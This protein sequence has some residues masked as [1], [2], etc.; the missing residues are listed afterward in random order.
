MATA[1]LL[2]LL[3]LGSISWRD[4]WGKDGTASSSRV[5]EFEDLMEAIDL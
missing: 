5:F 1:F 2:R 3:I 4:G